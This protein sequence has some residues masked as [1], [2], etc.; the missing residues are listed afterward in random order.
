VVK[1]RDR[2]RTHSFGKFMGIPFRKAEIF[3]FW[4]DDCNFLQL[5]RLKVMET[6]WKF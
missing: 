3:H 2:S 1:I 4:Y 6:V 5:Q